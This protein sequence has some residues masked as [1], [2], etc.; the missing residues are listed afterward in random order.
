MM[1]VL[2]HLPLVSH[3]C[4]T[5]MG[6][7]WFSKWP[8][9][10]LAPNYNH[11]NQW[12]LN[13]NH[14][15]RNIFWLKNVKINQLSLAKFCLHWG[16]VTH[17]CVSKLTII[18]IDNGLS[19]GRRQANIWTNAGILLIGPLGTNFSEIL[20]EIHIFSFRKMHLKM[21]SAKMAAILP[22]GRWVKRS[23]AAGLFIRPH[24]MCAWYSNSCNIYELN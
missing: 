4:V 1:G 15:R 6:P 18:D 13:M 2:T 21:S 19:P 11:L 9:S 23:P 7:H 20:I 17:I 14:T 12:W 22:S 8:V 24:C 5:E 10:C 16:G 3:I